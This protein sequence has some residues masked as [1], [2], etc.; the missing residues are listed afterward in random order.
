[1]NIKLIATEVLLFLMIGILA[2]ETIL[3]TSIREL[4]FKIIIT[5]VFTFI[6]YRLIEGMLNEIKYREKLQIAYVQL[7]KLSKAK[8]EFLSIASHQLRTP[9]TAIKGYVS[10]ILEGDYGKIPTKTVQPLK[11]IFESNERLLVLVNELLNLSRLEANK[12]TLST[13]NVSLRDLVDEI[14]KELKIN[15]DK[16]GLYVKLENPTK[17]IPEILADKDKLRLY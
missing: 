1:M 16:K 5:V 15:A 2:F 4:I 14:I 3:S 6:S 10:L 8:S 13:E 12:I 17:T 9:L 7:K 11:N